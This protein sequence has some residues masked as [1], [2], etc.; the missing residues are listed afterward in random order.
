MTFSRSAFLRRHGVVVLA[1]L[2]VVAAFWVLVMP[3]PPASAQSPL[4]VG[5]PVVVDPI[6]GA[7]EPDIVMDRAGNAWI[8][9]PGGSGAQ[10]SFFWH[11]R[12]GGLTFPHVGPYSS[13]HWLCTQAG[14]GD[15]LNVLDPLNGDLYLTDQEALAG[16][17]S[18]RVHDTTGV[19]IS[20]PMCH[21]TSVQGALSADRPFEGVLHSS[22]GA[23][24]PQW[25]ANGNKPMVY[26]S[27]LC[28][29]CGVNGGLAFAYSTDGATF[30]AAEPGTLTVPVIGSVVNT[31]SGE[32]ATVTS[33]SGHGPTVVDPVTGYVFTPVS[34]G[35]GE[36][37]GHNNI[38]FDVVVGKPPAVGSPADPGKLASIVLHTAANHLP[39]GG[40]ITE[41]GQLF[42]VMA[43][44]ANRTL[45]EAWAEGNSSADPNLPLTHPDTWHIYYTYSKIVD[46]NGAP[47]PEH[48][49]WSNP[50]RVDAGPQTATSDFA[51]FAVGD[52]GKLAFIWLGTDKREHPSKKNEAKLWHPFMAVTTNGDTAAPT[53]QQ[54]MVGRGPNHISDMCLSGTVGCITAVGNR[55]M[56]DFISVDIGADGVAQMTWANDS[57]RL[58][59]SPATLIPGLPV[60]QSARQVSGPKLRG[61]GD[62]SDARFSAVPT[63]GIS[64]FPADAAAPGDAADP[65]DPTATRVPQMD[66]KGSSVLTDGTNLQVHMPVADLSNLGSPTAAALPIQQ[67]VWWLTRWQFKNKIYFA[68]AENDLVGGLKFVAGPAKSFD[69]PGLNGQ[70]VATLVDY[71][72]GTTVSGTKKGNEWVVTV[73]PSV[74]G[75]PTT[76]D[77]LEQVTAYAITDNGLPLAVSPCLVGPACQVGPNN[78]IPTIFDATADYNALLGTLPAPPVTGG[79]GGTS[80]LPSVLPNTA[81]VVASPLSASALPRFGLAVLLVLVAVGLLALRR[82]PD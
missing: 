44:D 81:G 58:A 36:C 7:G 39:T 9:G 23:V 31:V 43:I 14:G 10:T 52:P 56:A 75:N 22:G 13:G 76:G 74:V 11:T 41:P 66:L 57:N 37:Q 33:F 6:R 55:N 79:G 38:E 20:G 29:A 59:T 80:P 35:V 50:V 45:Y 47:D 26:M 34:C 67:N 60:T 69:R 82:R 51:W 72:G 68:K 15:S 48:T 4:S 12:D 24:A 61:T 53:F 18:A 16:F 25:T 32:G 3:A 21:S 40:P 70:T 49:H 5:I 77:V 73:P 42:P 46:P 65:R 17:A 30:I 54:T 28:A 78:N 64:E 19:P 62:V 27:W 8:S 2:L 63:T 71:S 1:V